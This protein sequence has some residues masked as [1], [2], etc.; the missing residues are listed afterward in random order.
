M[1][2]KQPISPTEDVSYEMKDL[3]GKHSYVFLLNGT[4][5]KPE[6]KDNFNS[7]LKASL[8][9]LINYIKKNLNIAAEKQNSLSTVQVLGN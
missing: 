8:C 5:G 4:T 1:E 6:I 9:N 3:W 7:L 2:F